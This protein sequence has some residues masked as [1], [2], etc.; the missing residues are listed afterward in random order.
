MVKERC[1]RTVVVSLVS[2]QCK[3]EKWRLRGKKREK[4][5]KR[6][7]KREKEGNLIF[8]CKQDYLQ[9]VEPFALRSRSTMCLCPALR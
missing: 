9:G 8:E 1:Q 4:E 7:K 3:G 2:A 6:G 5:G